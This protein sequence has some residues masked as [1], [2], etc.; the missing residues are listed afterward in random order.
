MRSDQVEQDLV[1]DVAEPGR[2]LEQHVAADG[3]EAA[4]R[5]RQAGLHD[6]RGEG[7]G[8]AA[9]LQPVSRPSR[10]SSRCRHS[11]C[12]SPARGRHRR[13]PDRDRAG[14]VSSCCRSASITA[15][16]G[17][18]E[19]RAPSTT[20]EDSPRR[21]M[22]RIMRTRRSAWAMRVRSS[23]VPSVEPSST[24]IASHSIPASATPSRSSS[25][26]TLPTSLSVGM[27]TLSS[28]GA[29][30]ASTC[31]DD[32]LLEHEERALPRFGRAPCRISG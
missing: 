3:E 31:A 32:I 10:R 7:G 5:V 17:V 26:S 30:R 18:V 11:A 16:I 9:D 14:S 2:G 28:S 1:A 15:M 23:G 6:R 29:S 4:H 19:A 20:A 24:K 8:E 27:T 21:P 22:R 13:W 25:G 12:R